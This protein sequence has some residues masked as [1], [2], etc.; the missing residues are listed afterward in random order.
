MNIRE[1]RFLKN[2]TQWELSIKI[3]IPQSKISLIEN[4]YLVPSDKEKTKLA[5]A[6]GKRKAELFPMG[7]NGDGCYRQ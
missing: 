2:L 7:A 3:N 5:S 6:L 4:G 1:A